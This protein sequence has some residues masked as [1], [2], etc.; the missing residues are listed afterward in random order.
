MFTAARPLPARRSRIA[1]RDIHAPATTRG[2]RPRAAVMTTA[3]PASA[4]TTTAVQ[5]R[6][7][8]ARDP[9]TARAQVPTTAPARVRAEARGQAQ[10]RAA[11]TTEPV[12]PEADRA[13]APA[14]AARTT[15]SR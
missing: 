2:T 11:P 7:R 14:E 9:T 12:A 13:P 3:G 6:A 4:G 1:R 5:A 10:A 15:Q 8:R